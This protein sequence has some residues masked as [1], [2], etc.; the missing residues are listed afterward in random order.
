MP[1]N[2]KEQKRPKQVSNQLSVKSNDILVKAKESYEKRYKC[3][4]SKRSITDM[5]I[6][7]GSESLRRTY[8]LP[9]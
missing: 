2:T 5:I 9:K 6:K 3:E 8:R 7:R 1:K 4:I